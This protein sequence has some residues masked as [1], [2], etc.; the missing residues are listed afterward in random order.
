MS[1]N[2]KFCLRW[3][4]F[5]T[6]I[7]VAF[8]EIRDEKDF[9]DCTLSCGTR[10]IQAHKLILSACSPFFRSILKQNPHQHPLLYL[11]GV[12][13]SDL[14]SVLNFMYHGEVNVAQEELNSFLAVAEDL[15]VK[16]LTQ[17]NP[18]SKATNRNPKPEPKPKSYSAIENPEPPAPPRRPRPQPQAVPVPQPHQAKPQEDDYLE[19]IPTVKQ[20]PQPVCPMPTTQAVPYTDTSY[21]GEEGQQGQLANMEE[22]YA[23]E[24]Y[25]DYGEY[26]GGG[27]MGYEDNMGTSQVDQA[28]RGYDWKTNQ[29]PASGESI[30]DHIVDDP[31]GLGFTCALCGKGFG[32]NKHHCRRHIRNYHGQADSVISCQYCPKTYKTYDTLRDHERNKHGMYRK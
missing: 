7:S 32:V 19:V 13:F 1:S 17:S 15:Q 14:Q 4:D 16:G 31:T 28:T 6:N 10:Q 23:E 20:E 26:E 8:R 18:D 2:E 3:N 30:N 12:D 22:S 27:V 24:G 11:K 21:V 5:E 25:D 29:A 9:F